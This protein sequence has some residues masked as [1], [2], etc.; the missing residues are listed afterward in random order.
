MNHCSVYTNAWPN[1]IVCFLA[2][3]G[4]KLVQ[5][6]HDFAPFISETSSAYAKPPMNVPA[7][8]VKLASPLATEP[9]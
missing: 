2:E 7:K 6:K 3:L 4:H 8:I 5:Q 9:Q 1:E